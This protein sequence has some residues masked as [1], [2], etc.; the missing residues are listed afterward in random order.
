MFLRYCLKRVCGKERKEIEMCRESIYS[1]VL[2]FECTEFSEMISTHFDQ[3][4]LLFAPRRLGAQT[5]L[6][7]FHGG[8]VILTLR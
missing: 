3:T 1:G 4:F 8:V 2:V 5:I 6:V 7:S